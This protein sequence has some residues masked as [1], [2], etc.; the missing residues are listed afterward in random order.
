MLCN[1]Y[2]NSKRVSMISDTIA[3]TNSK[4]ISPFEYYL[5]DVSER[6]IVRIYLAHDSYENEW[7]AVALHV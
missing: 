3:L 5:T 4:E 6:S 1:D 2:D 7:R